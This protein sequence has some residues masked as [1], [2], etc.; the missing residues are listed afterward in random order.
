MIPIK[1]PGV[2]ND[3]SSLCF[4]LLCGRSV[5]KITAPSGISGRIL[6]RGSVSNYARIIPT[7]GD[8][9]RV[10]ES[11]RQWEMVSFIKNVSNSSGFRTTSPQ[12]KDILAHGTRTVSVHEYSQ[13]GNNSS[14][15]PIRCRINRSS[16]RQEGRQAGR[17]DR[18][19]LLLHDFLQRQQPNPKSST[20]AEPPEFAN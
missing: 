13:S 14:A 16:P 17:Q 11:N 19:D 2:N 5:S 9:L 12:S 4:I 6:F 15:Q 7:T 8:E 20:P 10:R 3:Q 18:L 1:W